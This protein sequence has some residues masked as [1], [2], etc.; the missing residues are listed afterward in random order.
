MILKVITLLLFVKDPKSIFQLREGKHL[1]LSERSGFSFWLETTFHSLIFLKLNEHGKVLKSIFHETNPL[2]FCIT[3]LSQVVW[4]TNKSSQAKV[5]N[6][7]MLFGLTLNCLG[8]IWV[9]IHEICKL[10]HCLL[11]EQHKHKAL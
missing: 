4:I 1:F 5:R 11:L 6:V 9:L 3:G 2:D 10:S 8:L 7:S